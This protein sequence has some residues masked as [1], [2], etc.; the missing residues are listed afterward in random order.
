MPRDKIHINHSPVSA[1]IIVPELNC[2]G[3]FPFKMI[4]RVF[5][6]IT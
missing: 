1:G 6:T 3:F 4:A 2:E 5:F